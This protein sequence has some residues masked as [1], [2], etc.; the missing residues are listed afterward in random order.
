MVVD[1]NALLMEL[2][3]E[4]GI[5][6][7][8]DFYSGKANKYI[9]FVYADERPVM[10]ADNSEQYITADIQVTLYTKGNINY[11]ADKAK[12]K[13]ALIDRG[14]NVRSISSFVERVT[15]GAFIRHTVFETEYTIY[16]EE[17]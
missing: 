9:V 17:V 3:A 10:F 5:E 12:V 6:V 7:A 2:K 16:N 4:T 8:P 13:K 1:A 14:F 11:M 15:D